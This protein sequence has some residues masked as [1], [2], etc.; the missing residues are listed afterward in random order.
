M[1]QIPSIRALL[2]GALGAVAVAA[3]G[4]VAQASCRKALLD[5]VAK[6]SPAPLVVSAREAMEAAQSYVRTHPGADFAIGSGNSMLPMYHDRAVIV[7]E[8]PALA[9]LKVGQTVVFMGSD[10]VP[11][12]HTL[13]EHTAKGWVTMGLGNS[14]ADEGY[15]TDGTYIGVVVKAYQPTS[16]PILSFASCSRPSGQFFASNP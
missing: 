15:V 4:S 10:G 11:V 6:Y 12:A 14:E 9:T 5:E 1:A 16:S 3:S 13:I 2:L 7:T 8:R